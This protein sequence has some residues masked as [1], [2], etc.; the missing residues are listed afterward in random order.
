MKTRYKVLIL[1][2]TMIFAFVGVSFAL[3][4]EPVQGYDYYDTFTY[5]NPGTSV[6]GATVYVGVFEPSSTGT[7]LYE[8]WFQ[9]ENNNYDPAGNGA[10]QINDFWL[11]ITPP[12]TS[13]VY[14][15]GHGHI[16]TV[17][18][19]DDG[20]NF[21]KVDFQTLST[22]MGPLTGL[23]PATG[24]PATILG[25]QVSL[26][27]PFWM[28]TAVGYREGTG[29]LYDSGEDDTIQVLSNLF[30]TG[31]GNDENVPEPGTLLLLGG[32]LLGLASWRRRYAK[33]RK[34]R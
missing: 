10:N 12:V 23:Q 31:G 22:P 8:Y 19:P 15:D 5:I 30:E 32:G 26:S 25:S 1:A 34:N 6:V 24:I 3:Y 7:G 27:N 14:D 20:T 2:T 29:F 28:I 16:P 21:L 33:S 17:I 11:P 13:G 9:V 4:V 18:A